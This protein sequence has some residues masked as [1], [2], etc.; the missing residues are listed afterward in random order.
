MSRPPST[1][2]AA[3]VTLNFILVN[4]ADGWVI[5]DVE[6]PHDFIADVFGAVPEFIYRLAQARE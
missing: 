4:G 6:S 2:T 3:P 5:T 1:I